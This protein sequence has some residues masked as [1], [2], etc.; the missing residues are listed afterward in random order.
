M[1]RYVIIVAILFGMNTGLGTRIDLVADVNLRSLIAT[2]QDNGEAGTGSLR[3][4][5]L[6][7]VLETGAQFLSERI[8]V[9]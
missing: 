4:E 6:S 7:L 2:D 8:T 9:E 3:R 5:F 1:R